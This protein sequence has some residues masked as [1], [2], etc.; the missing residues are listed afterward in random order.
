MI[1]GD[2]VSV[3]DYGATGD[4]V[5]DDTVALQAAIDAVAATGGGSLFL[6]QGVYK[7]T[8]TIDMDG[9]DGIRLLGDGSNLSHGDLVVGSAGVVGEGHH[10]GST[11]I[12]ADF[13]SGPVIR[14]YNESCE[15][16]NL[17][18]DA[19]STRKASS[20]STNYGIHVEAPD[21]AGKATKRLFLNRIRVT[22]QPSHGIVL[23]NDLTSSTLNFVD[24]DHC[25]GHGFYISGG[26][27]T[28]RTNKT[29][30]GQVNINNC[31]STRTGGHSILV[32]GN[33]SASNDIPYRILL[34]NF[35]GFYNCITPTICKNYVSSST[36]V[37]NAYL[38]G[39]NLS[40][41][42]TA[43]DGR[44]QFPALADTHSTL[45]LRGSH[46]IVDNYRAIDGNPYAIRLEGHPQL[47]NLTSG[48]YIRNIYINNRYQ[49]SGF[50]NPA[51][52]YGSDIRSIYAWCG[53]G[54]SDISKLTSQT[55]GTRFFEHF[56]GVEESEIVTTTEKVIAD[57]FRSS[58]EAIFSDDSAK[59][60]PIDSS[61]RGMVLISGNT[62]TAGS[63][64]VHFRVVD[65]LFATVI[66]SSGATVTAS[67]GAL[68]G[69]TGVDGELT[70]SAH[71]TGLYIENRTGGS[72]SYTYT[73]LS[74]DGSEPIIIS[75]LT[76]V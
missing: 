65:Y 29:R 36:D 39:E 42:N 18:I 16:S 23:I 69:T 74:L 70:V 58:E 64:L 59:Y 1:E 20:L 6:P 30:P 56:A 31:R 47:S 10:N 61:A 26:V 27:L 13:T 45:L 75:D 19:S 73:F 54:Y 63:A 71:T 25:H 9:S 72:A 17:T 7:T 2:I 62:N 28:S 38:S 11:R 3:K 67:T 49:S 51:I 66:T 15:I 40:I 37:S 41:S 52:Y 5:T 53:V 43:L 50:Y 44:S 34:D 55:A 22:N 35:E 4:G 12:L 24:V 76:D 33:E 8:A 21:D 68:T 46:L 60:I 14:I 48:V 57:T 32:G